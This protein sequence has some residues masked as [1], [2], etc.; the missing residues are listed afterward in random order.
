[1]ATDSKAGSLTFPMKVCFMPVRSKRRS[2]ILLR[3]PPNELSQV[4]A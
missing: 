4:G 2:S 3:H 1:M